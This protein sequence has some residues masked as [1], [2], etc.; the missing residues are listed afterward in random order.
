MKLVPEPTEQEQYPNGKQAETT[1]EMGVV[2]PDEVKPSEPVAMVNVLADRIPTGMIEGLK[3]IRQEIA[4]LHGQIVK[5]H[6]VI[7]SFLSGAYTAIEDA[8]GFLKQITKGREEFTPVPKKPVIR[9]TDKV[10]MGAH[11]DMIKVPSNLADIPYM[12]E[13]AGLCLF[14]HLRALTVRKDVEV[15]IRAN[16]V[17]KKLHLL[18]CVTL[19][20]QSALALALPNMYG[21]N[22]VIDLVALAKSI[23]AL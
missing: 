23:D 14:P 21:A 5:D 19:P 15:E 1:P 20:D 10:Y 7:P 17:K 6:N 13:W 4:V 18:I 12:Q 16:K 8:E 3:A 11:G 2:N 22:A 9:E